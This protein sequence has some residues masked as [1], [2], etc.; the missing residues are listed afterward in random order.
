MKVLLVRF[1]QTQADI[2]NAFQE[3]VSRGAKVENL[4]FIACTAERMAWPA[5]KTSPLVNHI[6]YLKCLCCIAKK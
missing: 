4:N 2:S 5:S 1:T 3:I 6:F